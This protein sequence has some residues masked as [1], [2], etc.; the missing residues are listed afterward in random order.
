[1]EHPEN[2]LMD[3]AEH[4]QWMDVALTMV[5]ITFSRFFVIT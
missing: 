5:W 4:R 3:D 1:M 2:L